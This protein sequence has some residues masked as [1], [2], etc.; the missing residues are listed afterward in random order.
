MVYNFNESTIR[1]KDILLDDRFRISKNFRNTELVASI[2][3][4]GMLEKPFLIKTDNYYYPL[5][6]HNRIRIISEID[7]DEIEAYILHS[8]VF[9]VFI[10]Y[11]QLKIYR[12]ECGPVGKIKAVSILR[13]E[14]GIDGSELAD[15]ARK[16]LKIP[17]DIFSEEKNLNCIMQ[18]PAALKDYI[19]AK[20]IPFRLIKDIISFDEVIITELNR[21]VEKVQ[22]RLNIF[23]MLVDF[24]FDIRKRD[25]G[26]KIIEDEALLKMDDKA[27]YD[28]VFSVRYP[29]YSQ[30]KIEA[31][32]L[33]SMLTGKGVSVE[34]PEFFEKDYISLRFTINRREPGSKINELVSGVDCKKIDALLGLL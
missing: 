1:V 32:K 15:L 18:L 3:S 6:C 9:E 20:D 27:L 19:D 2:K 26:L 16:T 28:Y 21:W 31:D 30:K 17:H 11:F 33:I 23:K 5:T 8:P 12:N 14:F 7:K 13:N 34:F 24:L 29:E 4:S 10:S 22:I 25:G